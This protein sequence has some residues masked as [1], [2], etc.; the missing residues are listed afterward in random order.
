MVRVL[1]LPQSGSIGRRNIHHKIINPL[2][3]F[4]ETYQVI[5]D[6][7]FIGSYFVFSNVSADNKFAFRFFSLFF[8]A[9]TPLLLN[10]ILLI[11]AS[12]AGSGTVL[13]LDFR[14]V[15]LE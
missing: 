4:P 5:I 12:S 6:S 14:P 1:K 15:V 10:P 8:T 7:I 2:P 13:V 9:S 11:S 3:E